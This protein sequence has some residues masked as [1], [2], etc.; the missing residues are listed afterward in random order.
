MSV[1]LTRAGSHGEYEQKFIQDNRVYV[2]WDGLDVNLD[3][4]DEWPKFVAAMTK[5]YPDSKPKT[6]LNWA[7]QVWPFVHEMKKGDLVVVPLKSQPAIQ[8][9]E[10]TGDY[11][12]EPKGPDPY[13]HWRPVK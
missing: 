8:F 6:I 4:L 2:T 1:W 10:I 9:G 13:F 7:S 12:F 5:H 3:K 11:Q